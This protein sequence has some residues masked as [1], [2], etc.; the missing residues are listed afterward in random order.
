MKHTL[1]LLEKTE[2]IDSERI[3]SSKTNNTEER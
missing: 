1:S 3:E 2:K